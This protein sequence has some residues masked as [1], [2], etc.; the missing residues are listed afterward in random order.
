MKPISIL[1]LLFLCC[2][3]NTPNFLLAQ[4][5]SR[6][7]RMQKL[8]DILLKTDQVIVLGKADSAC[9]DAL[10]RSYCLIKFAPL[11]GFADYSARVDSLKPRSP[12]DYSSNQT[13]RRYR[14][15]LKQTYKSEGINFAGHYCLAYWGCGSPCQECAIIDT[16]TGKV[17]DGP[18]AGNGYGY[19]KDSRMLIVNPPDS[20]GWYL[21]VPYAIPGVY[22]WNDTNK[23]FE[24]KN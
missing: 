2:I 18:S 7:T 23:K 24:Q 1:W 15:V 22:I 19:H 8:G 5:T 21:N 4:D 16:R 6:F 12:I 13:A 9:I 14:K 17:Y 20:N 11:I 3:F 10:S